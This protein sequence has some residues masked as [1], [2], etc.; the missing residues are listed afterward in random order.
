MAEPLLKN[1]TRFTSSLQN[2]L[3]PLFNELS[4]TT[5]IPKS[6]LLDEAIEDLL[7]KHG[8]AVPA[9]ERN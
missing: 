2:K 5:R 9:D 3:V 7:K 8:M 4:D 1:R 6:R